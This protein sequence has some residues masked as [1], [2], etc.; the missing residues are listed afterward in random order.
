MAKSIIVPRGTDNDGP[1]R[2]ATISGDC[3]RVPRFAFTPFT[4][5]GQPAGAAGGVGYCSNGDAGDPTG[6][7]HDGAVW[8]RFPL[9]SEINLIE[10]DWYTLG[11]DETAHK[12]GGDASAP[13]NISNVKNPPGTAG[14]ANGFYSIYSPD[15]GATLWACGE[16]SSFATPDTS[17]GMWRSTDGGATWENKSASLPDEGAALGFSLFGYG[18]DVWGGFDNAFRTATILKYNSGTDSWDEEFDYGAGSRRPNC[19]W[20]SALDGWMYCVAYSGV[21]Q[22][23][24][25]SNGGGGWAAEGAGAGL[26]YTVLL[27]YSGFPVTITGDGAGNLWT[28]CHTSSGGLTGKHIF[29]GSFGGPWTQEVR[30]WDSGRDFSYKSGRNMMM[31]ETGAIWCSM[32]EVATGNVEV[33]RRDPSTGVWALHHTF[34][35]AAVNGG[36]SLWVIDSQNIFVAGS[37]LLGIWDGSNWYYHNPCDAGGWAWPDI[38]VQQGVWGRIL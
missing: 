34:D 27:A 11:I 14:G 8:R 37:H 33:H 10:Y 32:S 18:G 1:Y 31:D 12:M 25:R 4:V 19:V 38:N 26:L 13:T 24:I 7:V 30:S 22:M 15:D 28:F 9:G 35:D 36:G 16:Y 23:L 3:V 5:A 20:G 6:C 17:N 29:K 21:S 2:A